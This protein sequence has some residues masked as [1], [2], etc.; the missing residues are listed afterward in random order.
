MPTGGTFEQAIYDLI[1]RRTNVIRYAG[2]PATS[3]MPSVAS[4]WTYDKRGRI[5]SEF[6]DASGTKYYS[7][8]PTDEVSK[9]ITTLTDPAAWTT[10]IVGSLG[11]VVE[12]DDWRW[13]QVSNCTWQQ[14]ADV[15][16]YTYDRPYS[17]NASRYGTT[18][19]LLASA[20]NGVSTLAFGY[21]AQH[22]PTL[23]DEWTQDN[24]LHS[25]SELYGADGRLLQRSITSPS[26]AAYN[27]ISTIGYAVGYDS[28]GRPA[29][30]SASMPRSE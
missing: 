25:V 6:A 16:T 26:L 3:G 1:G 20:M 12:R 19:G 21:D 13:L 14:T 22:V 23:R 18:D 5:A 29:L 7:Y 30:A 11:R 4:S 2:S 17:G 10:F 28:A 27:S 8:L 15:T 24:K 9:I